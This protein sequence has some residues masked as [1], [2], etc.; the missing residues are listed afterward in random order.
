[1]DY[2]K[3]IRSV[4]VLPKGYNIFSEMATTVEI[5][6]EAAGEFVRVSQSRGI[7]TQSILIDVGEWN[8]IKEAIDQMIQECRGEK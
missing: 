8:T 1:M 7:G 3:R 5:E 2:E 6:D 4:I